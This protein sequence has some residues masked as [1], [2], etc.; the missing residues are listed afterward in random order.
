VAAHSS[1]KRKALHFMVRVGLNYEQHKEGSELLTEKGYKQLEVFAGS[2]QRKTT[3]RNGRRE[4][5]RRVVSRDY[6]EA[7]EFRCYLSKSHGQAK[8][9]S[10]SGTD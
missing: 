4:K 8:G 1:E 9:V 2:K 7:V 10:I 6:R 5:I 3:I